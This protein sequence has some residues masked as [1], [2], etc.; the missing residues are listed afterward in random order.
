MKKS[1]LQTVSSAAGV[2]EPRDYYDAYEYLGVRNHFSNTDVARGDWAFQP[3][4]MFF[5]QNGYEN[6][7]K[8]FAVTLGNQNYSYT[9]GGTITSANT[10]GNIRQFRQG[11]WINMEGASNTYGWLAV[12]FRGLS[13]VPQ[14]QYSAFGWNLGNTLV[15]DS[16]Q[17]ITA[18]VVAS[19][20][21]GT[22][23]VKYTGNNT[24]N[25][26]VP[27]GL[28]AAPEMMIFYP[29]GGGFTI[30]LPSQNSY[31]S[32]ATAAESTDLT[33]LF[34]DGSS[35]VAP[36]GSN[37]TVGASTAV[38]NT[39]T[40][41]VLCFHSVENYQKFD[42]YT[43]SGSAG[44]SVNVGFKPKF[45]FIK[46]LD[47]TGGI[48]ITDS[49]RGGDTSNT[50]RLDFFNSGASITANGIDRTSTGFT[51]QTT[52]SDLNTASGEYFYWAIA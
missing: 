43:G 39:G 46:R 40:M 6:Q 7:A 33:T 44:K 26:T 48:I 1:L 21:S 41:N 23:L 42:T 27:H 13:P 5:V 49:E 35:Y 3:D 24:S 16:S 15:S 47:D 52:D 29:N 14:G 51:I 28:S 25:Q 32:N 4:F 20:V 18:D 12:D 38:N 37:F 8:F 36:T 34:G 50:T 2:E 45:L 19:P 31:L 22:S 10:Y 9:P 30:F 11:G 17:D